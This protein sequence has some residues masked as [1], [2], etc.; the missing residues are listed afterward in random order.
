MDLET[1]KRLIIC[2]INEKEL[3]GDRSRGNRWIEMLEIDS[4]A[5]EL[6]DAVAHCLSRIQWA[7]LTNGASTCMNVQD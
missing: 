1:R 6:Q 2:W 4:T 3:Q 7:E 5:M